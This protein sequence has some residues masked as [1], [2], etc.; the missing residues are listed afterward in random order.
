[1]IDSSELVGLIQLLLGAHGPSTW[2]ANVPWPMHQAI[3]EFRVDLASTRTLGLTQS[4]DVVPCP[5]LGLKVEG[6]DG[7]VDELQFL[8]QLSLHDCGFYSFWSVT[9]GCI[10]EYRRRVMRSDPAEAALLHCAAHRWS[11][12]AATS[13][14]N[15]RTAVESSGS[16]S[17]SATPMRR[18]LVA[19]A[20]R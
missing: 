9:A 8:G 16:T 14:K 18:Q 12:L 11:A 4:I 2:P 19:P 10:P 15:V 1:M 3:A 7:A 5:G 20:L 6:L 17:R 13:L